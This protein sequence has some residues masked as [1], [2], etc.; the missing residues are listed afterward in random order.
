MRATT[1][2]VTVGGLVAR[3]STTID[4]AADTIGASGSGWA[5]DVTMSGITNIAGTMDATKLV[6]TVTDPGYDAAGNAV[7]VTRTIRGIAHVR[8]QYPNGNSKIISTDGTNT[9]ATVAVDDWI[10]TGSTIVSAT[11]EAG[12]YPSFSGALSVTNNS[13]LAY[14]KPIFGWINQQR[15][16]VGASILVEAVAFHRHAKAGKQVACIK[17]QASDGTNVS[18]E[19]TV[20]DTA[21]STIQTQGNIAEVWPA[22]LTVSGLT[23]GV[24]SRVNA[25]VYPHI[26]D[27]SAVLDLATDEIAWPTTSPC[28]RLLF[29]RDAGAYGG[30]FAY[31]KVGATGG[32]VST[33]AATAQAAPFP[34]IKAALDA[35]V[36]WNGANRGHSTIGGATVRL[37]DDGGVAALHTFTS[38]VASPSTK[39]GLG[40][41]VIERDPDAVAVVSV[42]N[43]STHQ[44]PGNILVRNLNLQSHATGGHVFLGPNTLDA[45]CTL[46]ACTIDLSRAVSVMAWFGITSIINC[47]RAGTANPTLNGLTPTGGGVNAII[48]TTINVAS[49]TLTTS[50]GVPV[51]LIVGNVMPA[52]SVTGSVQSGGILYNNR[53]S[54]LVALNSTARTAAVGVAFVQNCAEQHTPTTSS[55]IAFNMFAD[56]DLTTCLQIVDM[57]NT[58]VGERCSRAYN[59]VAATRVAPSG[60][61]KLIT[62]MYS[63]YDNYNL[64]TDTFEVT[65]GVPLGM[66]N[67]AAYYNVGNRGNVSLFGAV[68]RSAADAPENANTAGYLGGAWHS[69]S[70]Y[71]LARLSSQTAVMDLFA[72]YTTQPR[73]SSSRGGDYRP[74][75]TAT[76]LKNRVPAGA[77]VLK[78]DLLGVLRKT[79]GTGAAGAYE[80]LP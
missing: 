54:H 28:T 8:R 48:G 10:Y 56:G 51:S 59:D 43:A 36:T 53:I 70:E 50:S 13:T 75:S 69:S 1:S 77:S 23:Q 21:L 61:I 79:D 2:I 20:G 38:A 33:T 58:G 45:C 26:G 64:K 32:T 7:T 57:H 3:N 4:P 76:A 41:C 60:L 6:L 63:V 39:T 71:N 18:S 55:S 49:D 5:V 11:A 42:Q 35:V 16:V 73:A 68:A 25:K 78:R 62:S 65:A 24:V 46:D 19:V 40:V 29:V 22:T 14:P 67:W 37:M 52:Q 44:I 9:T 47:I 30:A 27:A 72:N 31:V 66:G 34:T 80:A 17:F 12:F 74:I 15:A